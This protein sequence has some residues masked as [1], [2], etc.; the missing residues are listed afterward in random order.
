[1]AAR[2][3]GVERFLAELTFSRPADRLPRIVIRV[4]R[5]QAQT[6][7]D[8]ITVW[9]QEV[10]A[11]VRFSVPYHLRNRAPQPTRKSV[12]TVMASWNVNGFATKKIELK[13]ALDR[14]K[15]GIF[16]LQETNVEDHC[17]GVS[18]PGYN[19]YNSGLDKQIPGA[20]GV[21]LGVWKSL[22]SYLVEARPH[23]IMVKVIGIENEKSWNIVSCYLPHD[24]NERQRVITQLREVIRQTCARDPEHRTVF[25]GDFNM[26]PASVMR[27]VF[28]TTSE[29]RL[30]PVSGSEMTRQSRGRLKSLDHVLGSAEALKRLKPA[31]VRRHYDLSDHWPVTVRVRARMIRP[32]KMAD[33]EAPKKVHRSGLAAKS[34]LINKDERWEAWLAEIR[35]DPNALKTAEGL[36]RA[37]ERWIDTSW[38]IIEKHELV[39]LKRKTTAEKLPKSI[40]RLIRDR[41]RTWKR[42]VA[43]EGWLDAALNLDHKAAR[44]QL[45][46][47]LKL[48]RATLFS[49][50][51]AEGAQLFQGP[52]N[53]RAFYRWLNQISKF[54]QRS[55]VGAMPLKD[56][57]GNLQYSVEAIA[58]IWGDHFERLAT[59]GEELAGRDWTE[60]LAELKQHAVLEGVNGPLDWITIQLTLRKLK[61]GKAPGSDGLPPE[62][63]RLLIQ[64][65]DEV[66]NEWKDEP[67]TPMQWIFF[68]L[69]N[70]IWE[71]QHFPLAW[72]VAFVLAIPKK[73]D[74]TDVN[75][76]RGIS[77]IPIIL[78]ILTRVIIDRVTDK[79]EVAGRLQKEQAGFR[80]REEC[81]GQV[82]TLLEVIT[83]RGRKGSEEPT[84]ILF[85]DFQKAYDNVPHPAV[86][87]KLDRLGIRG[88]I[89]AFLD[90]LYQ[91]SKLTV[92]V[93]SLKS[94]VIA[95][96]KGIRQ[97]CPAS[98]TL[99]NVFINDLIIVLNKAGLGCPGILAR[100][101]CCLLFA[102]D[103][104]C[105][106]TT[107]EELDIALRTIKQWCLDWGLRIGPLKSGIMI[108]GDD[109]GA[110]AT[111]CAAI[112][113]VVEGVPIPIVT[114]YTYL[115]VEFCSEEAKPELFETHI[116]KRVAK[117][118]KTRNR[119][120][121]FLMSKTIPGHIRVH[122]FKVIAFPILRW[123]VEIMGPSADSVAEAQKIYM[124]TVRKIVGSGSQNKIYADAPLYLELGLKPFQQT[125]ME[126]RLRAYYKFPT[127]KT[128][129]ADLGNRDHHPPHSWFA[130]TRR[131]LKRYPRVALE[132]GEED[133]RKTASKKLAKYFRRRLEDSQSADSVAFKRYQRLNF[134]STRAYHKVAVAFPEVSRGV[135]WLLR[136]RVSG[137]WT[138]YK[139]A[140]AGLIDRDRK[141]TCALCDTVVTS[142]DNELEH[143]VLHCT[144][145][146]EAREPMQACFANLDYCQLLGGNEPLAPSKT[147]IGKW[148]GAKAKTWRESGKPGFYWVAKLLQEIMG[149]YMKALWDGAEANH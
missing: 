66:E 101:I 119:L 71:T 93:E 46:A 139:A 118:R 95:L 19:V 80:R 1:M 129:V 10:K 103:L 137:V 59:E 34:V 81:M 48:Y 28:N 141:G 76:Y 63:Y 55:R 2:R 127:L 123:G 120:L 88:E 38:M 131:W 31:K 99:F 113:R 67:D 90:K 122:V 100:T 25:L 52:G 145:F 49:K 149:P 32:R 104:V 105:A 33:A 51:I 23:W 40:R 27:R 57:D 98:T 30:L 54:R 114:E 43:A 143:M 3:Q 124:E 84:I 107:P 97:G 109:D 53:G 20:R 132:E 144:A 42:V 148:T 96:E 134:E 78:K 21:S 44:L 4:Q 79:L 8:A 12:R 35:A 7:K 22:R 69:L 47:A 112:D 45:K 128:L 60:R 64:Q 29:I 74:L 92:I 72:V 70:A 58:Q 6:V 115:G 15:V 37:A 94:R 140:Q 108:Y 130:Q 138:V 50:F 56:H 133:S 106:L 65:F 86:I 75:N 85:I 39:S 142:A 87:G 89:L 147:F 14:M 82:V 61:G 136:L 83:S 77:L 17:W 125:V 91:S 73:G 26:S 36:D 126:A 41:R 5:D 135:N 117:F 116:A 11:R 18:M 102:D 110:V 9:G 111:A 16:A 146:D 62:Y 121:P 68:L 13:A 24:R